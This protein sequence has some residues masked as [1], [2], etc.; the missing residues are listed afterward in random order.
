MERRRRTLEE[1]LKALYAQVPPPPGGLAEGRRRMFAE[2]VQRGYLPLEPERRRIPLF[3]RLRMAPA[4]RTLAICAVVILTLAFAG[5]GAVLASGDSLPGDM[6]YPIKLAIEDFRLSL[7]ADP[8]TQAER[9]MSFVGE[10]V[11][12]MRGLTEKGEA[13]PEG[14]VTRMVQ[15]IDRIVIDAAAASPE[16]A[17]GL[18]EHL[19]EGM[20]LQQQVLEQMQATGSP[21]DQ[22]ALNTALRVTERAYQAADLAKGDPKR[23]QYEY[24]HQ[25]RPEEPG[26]EAPQPEYNYQHEAE[27]G[28]AIG[29]PQGAP[30]AGEGSGAGTGSG[31][32]AGPGSGSGTG[33]GDDTDTAPDTAPGPGPGTDGSGPES[34]VPGSDSSTCA[35]PR[36]SVRGSASMGSLETAPSTPKEL[37]QSPGRRYSREAD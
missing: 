4:F 5:G 1:E 17:P 26:T 8:V 13:I 15:Q 27:N 19:R 34:S 22:S 37:E 14:V 33:S 25:A 28:E 9:N 32:G 16:Q 18:L 31:A 2:A 21:Q 35:P 36:N 7:T 20:R 29:D 10:R 3:R 30:A 11:E 24:L 23:L 12:E 6:L